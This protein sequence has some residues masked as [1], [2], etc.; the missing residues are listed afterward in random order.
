M[1]APGPMRRSRSLISFSHGYKSA[2]KMCLG[3]DVLAVGVDQLKGCDGRGGSGLTVFSFRMRWN[4]LTILN[5][6]ARRERT[7]SSAVKYY[8]AF[9]TPNIKKVLGLRA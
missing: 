5:Q 9:P 7:M 2:V 3:I 6:T 1:A 4:R 8:M